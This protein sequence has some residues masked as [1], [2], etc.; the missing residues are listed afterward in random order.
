VDRVE[1][2][3]RVTECGHQ[4]PHTVQPEPHPEQLE[5]QQVSL[6]LLARHAS[7]SSSAC[8]R[9]SL[10]RSVCTTSAGAFATNPWLASFL[11][12]RSISVSSFARRAAAF[13]AAPPRSSPSEAKIST[14]P[15]GTAT[16]ATGSPPSESAND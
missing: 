14:A 4:P 1:L 9:A 13:R 3:L 15:P 12:A 11:S 8:R 6:R 16:E 2:A 10:S 5:R 7:P